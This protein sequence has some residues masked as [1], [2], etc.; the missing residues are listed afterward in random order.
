MLEQLREKLE[1]PKHLSSPAVDVSM[2]VTSLSTMT[3]RRSRVTPMRGPRVRSRSVNATS[4][5]SAL[6]KLNKRCHCCSETAKKHE[7]LKLKPG[8]L[9]FCCEKQQCCMIIRIEPRFLTGKFPEL[10]IQHYDFN[11]WIILLNVE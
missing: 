8:S 10:H 9:L 6:R 3:I 2:V 5:K 7:L 1:G 11:D 4:G